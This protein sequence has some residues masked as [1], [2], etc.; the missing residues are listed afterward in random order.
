MLDP[1]LLRTDLPA[2]AA[3]LARRGFTLDVAAFAALEE[4][5]KSAQIE[6]DRLRAE[7]NANA[8]AVGILKAKKEDAAHLLEVARNL[9]EEGLLTLE[10]EL[11]SANASLM[12][13]GEK[14]EADMQD[15]VGEL[16]KKHAFER[17]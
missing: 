8:K 10:G 17:G 16:Q 9:A 1:K 4:Q 12:A 6:A 11:A 3:Q 2:V 13:Q 5:R 15:A 14:F 7:R